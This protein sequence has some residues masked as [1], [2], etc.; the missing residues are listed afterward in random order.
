MTLFMY[1]KIKQAKEALCSQGAFPGEQSTTIRNIVEAVICQQ[2]VRKLAVTFLSLYVP[3]CQ[4]F[5]LPAIDSMTS[6]LWNAP[7]QKH[8]DN[9]PLITLS[10]ENLGSCL[11][12][13]LKSS[14]VIASGKF[15]SSLQ[16][17]VFISVVLYQLAHARGKSQC[18]S[19]TNVMIVLMLDWYPVAV[20]HM[21]RGL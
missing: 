1:D 14:S 3:V 4:D 11:N 13:A 7:Q 2:P 19:P 16:E 12:N 10:A 20:I 15:G 5:A 9:V 17:Q 18:N 6:L 21:I 8:M